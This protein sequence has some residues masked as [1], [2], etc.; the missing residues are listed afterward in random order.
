MR[1][2]NIE[3]TN[4]PV[5][6]GSAHTIHKSAEGNHV[7]KTQEIPAR[8]N[9]QESHSG[10]RMNSQQR[11]CKNQK[12]VSNN[13]D[14]GRMFFASSDGSGFFHCEVDPTGGVHR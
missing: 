5:R 2:N 12:C 1:N 10:V 8:E 11:R 7:G 13:T 4:Q 9:E 14:V 3:P 6:K